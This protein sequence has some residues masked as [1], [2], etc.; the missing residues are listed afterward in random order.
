MQ[1][2]NRRGWDTRLSKLKSGLAFCLCGLLQLALRNQIHLLR[3]IKCSGYAINLCHGPILNI[4][5]PVLGP[6]TRD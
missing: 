6:V 1:F 3:C 4:S 5:R 2:V